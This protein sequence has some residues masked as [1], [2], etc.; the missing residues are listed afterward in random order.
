MISANIVTISL[1]S[2]PSLEVYPPYFSCDNFSLYNYQFPGRDDNIFC[3]CTPTLL[4]YDLS[5]RVN[6]T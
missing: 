5:Y 1:L 6:L 3:N 2:K 4:V